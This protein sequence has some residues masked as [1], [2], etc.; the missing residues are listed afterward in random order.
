MQLLEEMR[1]VFWRKKKLLNPTNISERDRIDT[2]ATMED[3]GFFNYLAYILYS[4]LY[5]VGPIITFNDFVHQQRYPQPTTSPT[6]VIKYGLRLLSS[7]L[8]MELAHY[9]YVVAISK[10]RHT[11]D[12]W[13]SYTPFQLSM[14]GNHCSALALWRARHRSFNRWIVRYIYIPFSGASRPIM[15]VVA[16]FTLVALWHDLS[17]KPLAWGW[18]VVLFVIPE[19]VCRK[20]RAYRYLS[21]L[22][23]VGNVLMM[24]GAANLVGFAIEAEGVR[25][26]ARGVLGSWEGFG[27]VALVCTCSWLC[28]LCM[29][30]EKKKRVGIDLRC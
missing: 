27:F 10:T 17:F 19:L 16:V 24:M 15:N 8:T 12:A 18:L 23:A 4:P 3:Y 26:L 29:R 6:L 21:G 1:E 22:G 7:I 5:L 14:I 30:L 9:L 11:Y 13:S 25:D 20:E 2:L 28:R